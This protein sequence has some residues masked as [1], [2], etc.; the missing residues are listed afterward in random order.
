ME[1][2]LTKWNH[3]HPN[4]R[5][6]PHYKRLRKSD[7]SFRKRLSKF[8]SLKSMTQPK[9]IFQFVLKSSDC[10]IRNWNFYNHKNHSKL[11]DFYKIKSEALSETFTSSEDAVNYLER[12][13]KRRIEI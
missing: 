8:S 1:Q 13:K 2:I 9:K 3:A 6:F 12:N 4:K 11:S 7:S 10:Q 5:F